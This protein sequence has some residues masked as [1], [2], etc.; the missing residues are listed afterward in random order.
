MYTA[1]TDTIQLKFSSKSVPRLAPDAETNFTKKYFMMLHPILFASSIQLKYYI[2]ASNTDENCRLSY[3]RREKSKNPFFCVFFCWQFRTQETRT[4]QYKDI[5]AYMQAHQIQ[6]IYTATY[7]YLKLYV[8]IPQMCIYTKQY[9]LYI[10]QGSLYTHFLSFNVKSLQK[11]IY[12]EREISLYFTVCVVLY[13][14][15][16]VTADVEITAG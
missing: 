9:N 5:E 1:N 14:Q 2:G 3:I 6:E 15:T 10:L 12:R 13:I 11:Y 7:I 8:Q 4:W 16:R